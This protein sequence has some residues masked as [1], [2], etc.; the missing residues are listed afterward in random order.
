MSV[1][2]IYAGQEA[3]K[4]LP[5]IFLVGPTP[6]SP[7][8]PSWRP[9]AIRGLSLAR[10]LDSQPLVVFV[11]EDESGGFSLSYEEQVEW[12]LAALER[13][14]VVMAWVPRDLETMPAF[15]TNVEFGTLLHSGKLVYGR[16]KRAPKTRY[17]DYRYLKATG[18]HPC[19]SL[20][21]LL[22]NALLCVRGR[23]VARQIKEAEDKGLYEAFEHLSG[24]NPLKEKK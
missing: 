14:T 6:R 9:E 23:W 12:E 4:G 16:P 19:N 15:T 5:S 7:D 22:V 1:H 21:D 13:A 3:P 11:P 8:V 24:D 10:T 17:L 2:V 18:W 20:P